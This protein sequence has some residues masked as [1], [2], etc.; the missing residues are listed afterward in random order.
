MRRPLTS[1]FALMS[2]VT[3]FIP[4]VQFISPLFAAATVGN[5]TYQKVYKEGL[6][7]WDRV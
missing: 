2:A 4:V 1:T 3:A 6:N 7:L 5:F